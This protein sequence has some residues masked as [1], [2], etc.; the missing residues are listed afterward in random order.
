[1]VVILWVMAMTCSQ[2]GS[3]VTEQFVGCQWTLGIERIGVDELEG[4]FETANCCCRLNHRRMDQRMDSST[5]MT[6]S[7]DDENCN[8]YER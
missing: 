7:K 8:Y 6:T 4:W 2:R 5:S 3:C 1:M